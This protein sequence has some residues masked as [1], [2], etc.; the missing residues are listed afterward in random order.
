[1]NFAHLHLL[2][3]HI[4]VV[5]I[6][7]ALLFLSYGIFRRNLPMQRFSLFVLIG[8]SAVVVPV[9][10][11]GEP[12]EKLIEHLP[13]FAESFIKSHEDAALI[14]L[15]LTILAGIASL[16][17]LF[18][19]KDE[20]KF[21]LGT[22]AVAGLAFIALISLLYTANLGGKVRHTELRG[23]STFAVPPTN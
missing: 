13:G 15:D 2:M 4:P 8:L 14:S 7:V 12:A 22:F 20:E 23:D 1:M 9:Y 6:P 18:V 16:M 10:L 3:N 17:A 11:T 5:G 21:R 19:R